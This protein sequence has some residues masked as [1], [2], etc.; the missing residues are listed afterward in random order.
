MARSPFDPLTF[1]PTA[2]AIRAK[3]HE[4]EVLAHRLRI[5]LAVAEQLRL[6]LVSGADVPQPVVR[7]GAP[8]G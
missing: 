4:A 7:E 8:R 3:L 5:L 6:P 1:I 2:E